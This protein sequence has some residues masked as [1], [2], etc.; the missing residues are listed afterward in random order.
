MA[1]GDKVPADCRIVELRSAVLAIDES[2]LTGESESVNKH[3][4]ALHRDSGA[5]AGS[6]VAIVNQDK[7][8]MLFSGTLVVR[9][10]ARAVVVATGAA[11]EIGA[12]QSSL[13]DV[14]SPKT[15]LQEKLDEFSEQLSKIIGV[16]CVLVW[17][18][19]IGHFT[20]PEHGGWL[21]GAVYYF[22]IAVALAVAAIPEGLPAVV[23]TCL[24]LGTMK[25]AR[26]NAIVRS[27]PSV[28]TL[29]CATVICSDKTGT[30]T[31]NQMSV[32]RVCVPQLDVS[33]AASGA[34]SSLLAAAAVGGG[35]SSSAGA[36]VATAANVSLRMFDVTGTSFQPS[37]DVLESGNRARLRYPAVEVPALAEVSR[38]CALCNEAALK[39]TPADAGA[40]SA[41]ARSSLL[42]GG[43]SSDGAREAYGKVGTATE[44]ALLVL[45]EKIGVADEAASRRILAAGAD[46][47]L[48]PAERVSAAHSHWRQ[49]HAVETFL[50]FRRDRKSMSVVVRDSAAAANLQAASAANGLARPSLSDPSASD[51][52][53]THRTLLC[54]GA[55]ETVLARCAFVGDSVSSPASSCSSAS[56]VRPSTASVTVEMTP[57]LRARIQACADEWAAQ[58]L[59]VLALA[60]ID[61]LSAA[62]LASVRDD[63]AHEAIESRMTFV[64]LVGMLDPP[65][66]E[67]REAIATCGAAGIRV[68]VITGDN[69]ATAEAIC[70]RIGVFDED[71]LVNGDDDEDDAGAASA[72]AAADNS[73]ALASDSASLVL[74]IAPALRQ[75]HRKSFT[76][77]EFSAMTPLQQDECVRH[78]RLFSRVEPAHKL[79]LVELLQ[80]QSQNVVAMTGDGV[81]D[82]PALA[83]ADIGI[84]MGSGTAVA[85]EASKM[86]LQDDN[87]ATIVMAVAEGRCIYANTRQF[88]RYLISS[89]IGE[90]V[91]IFATAALGMPEALIP[92]QLLWVNLVTD[93][94]PATALG[95]N[96]PD[97]DIMSQPPRGR[98]ERII[99]SW[100]LVRYLVIGFYIGLGTVAGFVWYYMWYDAGP[101]VTW[102]QLT[103]FH[104]CAAATAAA[105]ASAAADAS[106]GA[107]AVAAVSSASA[108]LFEGVDCSV[109]RGDHLHHASTIALSVLVVI[110][111]F[112]ALNAI[113]ENQSLLSMP[114]TANKWVLAAIATSMALHFL[115]LYVPFLQLIFAVAP[116][117]AAEWWAVLVISLPVIAIDE[118]LKLVSRRV[119]APIALLRRRRQMGEGGDASS[120]GAIPLAATEYTWRNMCARLMG[121]AAT[122]RFAAAVSSSS[123][124]SNVAYTLLSSIELGGAAA[125]AG[126]VKR[127]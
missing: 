61:T 48:T 52:A 95:F 74:P 92:V 87:F 21:R 67:V 94:L 76:G 10:S 32:Q 104:A 28:E 2:M 108:A 17:V 84:A 58:G 96:P 42:S 91:C 82:A 19:N 64:G 3:A 83:R 44:A 29:G 121:G 38:V 63:S 98:S 88:I 77:A 125:D 119:C 117:C 43:S 50:E 115:I 7:R 37:G 116:L 105:G 112:N 40:S 20:D 59:R 80:T 111:M 31:T 55:P 72:A 33:S 30:L 109:F 54:K 45:A 102:A 101:H 113:S 15:P 90:V 70:R 16:I 24:A 18:I 47:V 6:A 78:A 69:K 122:Q 120:G 123:S 41:S 36:G 51:A 66:A 26:K 56:S 22:K 103:H 106:A 23:T 5:T 71:E 27:L 68:C 124:T 110:E 8:N 79:R 99:D 126:A 62:A 65:R 12:V 46:S 114:P 49:L 75:R 100:T 9:G 118:V 1:S 14:E 60:K 89:N 81:N 73:G 85:R 86:V 53:S 93:G 11:T 97:A 4:D 13:A 57:A 39:F 34:G 107:V 35:S 25:M 127:R